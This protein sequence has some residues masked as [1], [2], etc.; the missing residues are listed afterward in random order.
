MMS[1]RSRT[2]NTAMGN[3]HT[4]PAVERNGRV[5]IAANEVDLI[6]SWFAHQHS[7]SKRLG[8]ASGDAARQ[9]IT[10]INTSRNDDCL[11]F[12]FLKPAHTNMSDG[13][14]ISSGSST[15]MGRVKEKV[16]PCGELSV[17]HKPPPC[18]STMERLIRSPMPRP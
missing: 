14:V 15:G 13:F 18:D 4:K 11:G 8:G 7:L 9:L 10:S 5:H 16:A 6:E 12:G 17:A 2:P 3:L 1:T